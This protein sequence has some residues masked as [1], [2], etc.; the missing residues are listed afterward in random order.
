MLLIDN[1]LYGTTAGGGTFGNG[2]VFSL[3]I[4][5][6]TPTVLASFNGTNGNQPLGSLTRVGNTLYGTTSYGG[7]GHGGINNFALFGDGTVFSVPVTGG[8]PTVLTS[9][10]GSD[11]LG[12][13]FG[14][15]L[16]GNTLYGA[17]IGGGAF[18]NGYGD[19]VVFSLPVSGGPHS[20]GL[21]QRQQRLRSKR[22]F[23][24]RREQPVRDD[25]LRR[26][27]MAM[28]QFSASPLAAAP[29]RCW[30]RSA[31]AAIQVQGV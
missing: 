20:T 9:F 11:G 5:G 14:L 2:T 22:P 6:G 21:L 1:T 25:R 8:T 29:L 3:P 15:T 31:A 7:T 13:E 12:P 17:C 26:R 27:Q 30:P 28:A 23:D 10:N 19:G 4:S 24:A 18:G 16:A